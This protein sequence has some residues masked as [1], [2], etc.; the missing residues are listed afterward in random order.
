MALKLVTFHQKHKF[1][2]ISPILEE[3]EE[4]KSIFFQTKLKGIRQE[5]ILLRVLTRDGH[6]GAGRSTNSKYLCIYAKLS[7]IYAPMCG[8]AH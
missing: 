3:K 1:M 6:A 4:E 7:H 5:A 8:C 2:K